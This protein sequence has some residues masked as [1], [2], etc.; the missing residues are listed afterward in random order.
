[1]KNHELHR[2]VAKL[3]SLISNQ[4]M[5]LKDNKVMT[6]TFWGHVTSSITWP[7]E[8]QWSTSYGWFTVTV[9]LSG[10]VMEIWRL[11]RW[12]HARTLKWFYTIALDRQ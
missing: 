2:L 4:T 9:D 8:S 1:M 7:F 12:M 6:L 11:K 10:T 3:K 5:H